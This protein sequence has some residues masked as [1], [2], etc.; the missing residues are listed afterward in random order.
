MS[1]GPPSPCRISSL[2]SWVNLSPTAVRSLTY[3]KGIQ[4]LYSAQQKS[5][6]R[7]DMVEVLPTG[8]KWVILFPPHTRRT[9]CTRMPMAILGVEHSPGN[10]VPNQKAR[11]LDGDRHGNQ[12]ASPRCG[13]SG[14][15]GETLVQQTCSFP[16]R[17]HDSCSNHQQ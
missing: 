11:E 12:G 8:L 1:H 2:P 5:Q 10:W 4:T 16:F 13:G 17:Q 15:L 9:R 6:G 3:G 14:H 7:P